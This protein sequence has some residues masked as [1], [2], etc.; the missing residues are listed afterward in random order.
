MRTIVLRPSA[1]LVALTLLIVQPV[2]AAKPT[3]TR[4]ASLEP[5]LSFSADKDSYQLGE[6]VQLSWASEG[7]RF[8]NASGDWDGKLS[9]SGVFRTQP[10]AGP[11]TYYLKCASK[12]GGVSATVSVGIVADEPAP[13]PEAEP[14]PEPVVQAPSVRLSSSETLVDQ[15]AMVTLSW[16]AD[17]AYGCQASGGWSGSRGTSGS[18]S[19]GPLETST[20]F[21]L[22]CDGEGGSALQMV[23]VSTLG[24]ISISWIAPQENVDGTTLT[25]LASYRIYYGTESRAYS[26]ILNVAN[27][28]ATSHVFS[29]PPGDYY[30][31]MTALDADGNESAYANEIVRSIP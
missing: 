7:T 15:G 20:T 14:A 6:R 11:A 25:D 17:H 29:A 22:S 18:E 30:I 2:I 8:C 10:L 28:A 12:R 23:S 24:E 27:S 19:V 31:T 13:L 4:S 26:N 3:S 21:T 1:Y 9:T 16:S 5:T